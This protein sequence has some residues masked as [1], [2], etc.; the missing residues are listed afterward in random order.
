MSH[1]DQLRQN[2]IL[3]VHDLTVAYGAKKAVNQISFQIKR[4][5]IFGLLG[6]NGA[7]KT[8]ALSAIEGLVAPLSGELFLEGIDIRQHPTE[9]KAKMGVQLQATSFQAVLTINQIVKL[10]PGSMASG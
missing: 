10:S 9:A 5:E 6:P 4:G 3:E 7:G 8:S 2:D 1:Q